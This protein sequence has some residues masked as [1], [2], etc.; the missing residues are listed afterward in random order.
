MIEHGRKLNWK[1][2]PPDSRDF[3]STRHLAAPIELPSEFELNYKIPVY[4]QK[5]AGSCVGN[6]SCESFRYESK[7]LT[8]NY[9]FEP[10]RLFV[11]WNARDIDGSTGEDAGTYIRSGFKAMNKSGLCHEKLHPYDDAISSVIKKPSSEAY[12]DGLKN[13]IVQYAAVNQNEQDIKATL[14]SGAVVVFG[15]TVYDSFFGS[16]ANST[17]IMPLPKKTEGIQGGHCVV[18]VGYSDSKK[19]FKIQNS[20]G[21]NWGIGGYF[22]MPYS[23]LLDPK[24][25]DDFWAI[26]SIKI[27]AETDPIPPTPPK[28]SE[29]DWVT[30]SGILFKTAKELYAVKK[31]TIIRLGL[32]LGLLVDEKKN[33]AYNFNLVKEKL[34][35]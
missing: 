26:Q 16:W 7:E 28:P 14:V 10:S 8:G 30:V 21:T 31:P 1:P 20:W 19:C 9:D 32:A 13:S 27:D 22:W 12:N 5:N 35:L 18:I 25:A 29:I 17:G 4:D 34:G 2:S 33:F 11:Y 24:Q 15:F 3:K 23:F 6:G